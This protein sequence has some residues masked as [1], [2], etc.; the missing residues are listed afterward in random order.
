MPLS[1]A[2]F[3]GPSMPSQQFSFDPQDLRNLFNNSQGVRTQSQLAMKASIK[4][5]KN[6]QQ[7]AQP[8]P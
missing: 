8:T 5:F 7:T 2:Q 4:D 3:T 6:S 1:N